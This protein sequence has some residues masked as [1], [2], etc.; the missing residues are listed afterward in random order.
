MYIQNILSKSNVHS[1]VISQNV[2]DFAPGVGKS[3]IT[4]V[5]VILNKLSIQNL[6]CNNSARK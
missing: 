3:I 4:D 5:F 2:G 6:V 1:Y